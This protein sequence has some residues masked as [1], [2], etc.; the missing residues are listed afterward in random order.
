M[1]QRL[2]EEKK[3]K[4]WSKPQEEEGICH[5]KLLPEMV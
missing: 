5:D 1:L 3:I 4:L 2:K